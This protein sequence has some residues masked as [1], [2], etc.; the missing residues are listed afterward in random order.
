MVPI[1][2]LLVALFLVTTGAG[3]TYS[4]A[5]SVSGK[6]NPPV[7]L[8]IVWGVVMGAVAALLI[9]L[10]SGGIGALQNFIV[11]TAVPLTFYYFP[12]LWIGPKCAKLMYEMQFG[13]KKEKIDE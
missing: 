7:W 9:K 3:M 8:R 1:I 5:I 12:T 11:F 13:N 2:L 6:E 10:G 4:M